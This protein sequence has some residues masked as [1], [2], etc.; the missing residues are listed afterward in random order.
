MKPLSNSARQKFPL[1]DR[2]KWELVPFS[3]F[4]KHDTIW[5]MT[6][7]ADGHVYI[8]L[9]CEHTAGGI[10][11]LY[12]YHVSKRRL[13]YCADMAKVTG[14]DP[15]DG[16]ATQGKIHFSLC[17]ASDGTIF[18]T[19]HCTTPPVGHKY[20]NAYGMWGD[21][22][23]NYPGGHIFQHD[24]HRKKTVDF[25]II[26][27]NEGLPYLLLDE[28][29]Q[30]L[31]GVTYPRA[32]FFRANLQGRALV[33]YGRISSWYPLAMVFDNAGNIFTSDTNSRLIKYDVRQDRLYFFDSAPYAQDWNHSR[34]FSWISNLLLAEDG[35]IYGTHYSND[36]L[37]R[38]N[39]RARRPS[40]EDLGPGLPD[41]G[42]SM[43]RALIPDSAGHIYYT[44]CA[45]EG[46]FLIRY[47]IHSGRK[48]CLGLLRVRGKN[49]QSWMGVCDRAGNIYLKAGNRPV[50]LAIYR[51][52]A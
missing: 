43:L 10:A 30:Y 9:C 36:R 23:H 44:A 7:G 50:S 51:P 4:P 52:G 16:H 14:E 19:T 34:R 35:N 22:V 12:R 39:P 1:V 15:G 24:P 13:E 6:L 31:Y 18:G 38:F 46:R 17:P 21:P 3:E 8:G 33:D 26:F 37:F 49:I 42:C 29:R 41:M 28:R 20:W 48:E 2:R 45:P 27:P 32:H 47:T 11:Q 5:S 40:F 25:G